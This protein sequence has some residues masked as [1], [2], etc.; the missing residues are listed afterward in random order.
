MH[1]VA[2]MSTA[3]NGLYAEECSTWLEKSI[4]AH[5]DTTEFRVRALRDAKDYIQALLVNAEND[6]MHSQEA[7]RIA[8]GIK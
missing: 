4:Q 3:V 5:L 7:L 2:C 6:C 8:R 1:R